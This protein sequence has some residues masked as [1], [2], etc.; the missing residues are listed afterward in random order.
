[1]T[2]RGRSPGQP[3][4]LAILDP[5]PNLHVFGK[6]GSGSKSARF[7]QIWIRI[8]IRTLCMC[9]FATL[10]DPDP[11]TYVHDA[12]GAGPLQASGSRWRRPV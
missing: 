4:G 7:W 10:L 12:L 5:D 6:S 8:Q 3:R 1:M 2:A 11:K 9:T